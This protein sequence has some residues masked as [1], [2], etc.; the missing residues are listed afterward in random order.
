MTRWVVIPEDKAKDHPLFGI[1]G[2]AKFLCS[3]STIFTGICVGV[4]FGYLSAKTSLQGISPNLIHFVPAFPY[5][6]LFLWAGINSNLLLKRNPNFTK[7]YLAF[8][9][10]WP[11]I[12][13]AYQSIWP[14]VIVFS[15]S[16]EIYVWPFWAMI[17]APYF[18]FSKRI[19]I[20]LFH[21][22]EEDDSFNQYV[23]GQVNTPSAYGI[24]ERCRLKFQGVL[25]RANCPVRRIGLIA[26]AISSVYFLGTAV[27]WNF[28]NGYLLWMKDR[29]DH[30]VIIK[31]QPE[32]PGMILRRY[33]VQ[34]TSEGEVS[35]YDYKT[36]GWAY[37]DKACISKLPMF[38]DDN[39]CC[40][41]VIHDKQITKTSI[42][43]TF[44]SY[45]DALFIDGPGFSRSYNLGRPAIIILVIG[46]F[47]YLGWIDKFIA[48]VRTGN[49]EN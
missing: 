1:N 14:G 9:L 30:S 11:L 25:R 34:Q 45:F 20:T 8:S 21:R 35:T 2:L 16:Y 24:K 44:G 6:L 33:G 29:Y 38:E 39:K 28:D 13:Y 48:W 49:S 31:K 3:I 18:I 5:V 7:S 10:S 26:I 36:S 46:L 43:W 23:N 42:D 4:S 19:K 37:Y 32:K 47:M 12:H 40:R 17:L 22:I 27:H 41:E 15:G